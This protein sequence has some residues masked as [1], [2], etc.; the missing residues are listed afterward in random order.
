[1]I[2][3]LIELSFTTYSTQKWVISASHLLIAHGTQ[4]I[5]PITTKADLHQ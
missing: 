4:E 3:R 5:K 1:L 2:L